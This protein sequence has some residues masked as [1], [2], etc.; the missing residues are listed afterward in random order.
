M[1]KLSEMLRV[2]TIVILAA[3]VIASCQPAPAPTEAPPP[4]PA[5]T[6]APAEP[7]LTEAPAKTE[8]PVAEGKVDTT[9]YKKDGPYVVCFSNASVSNSWRVSMVEHVRYAVDVFKDKGLIKEYFETDANDDPNKQISDTEDLLSKGCDVLIVSASQSEPLTPVVE[10]AFDQ[11]IPVV[12]LDR[13]IASEKYVTFVEQNSCDMGA[14]QAEWLV[15]KIGKKGNVVLLSG[16]AGATP[17][18]DRLRCAQET[19]AKYPDIKVLAQ[20]YASWS[21]VEGKKIMENWLVTFPQI[22]AVWAD[23]GLQ[24]SGAVEAFVEAG[25]DVPPITGE[26]FNRYLKQWKEMGFEGYAVSFNVRMGYKAVEI[27]LA[28]LKGLPVPHYVS[29]D[30]IIIDSS[31]LDQYVRMDLPDDYWAASMPE[32]AARLFP[33][34]SFEQPTA[35]P[36]VEMVD[37]TKYKKDGPYVVCFSNASVSNSWRVS[38]VEHVRYA[39]DVFKDKGLIKEYFETDANDDPNK[40]ISDTEDLL[41]KGCDVLI[42]SAS[43]SEPLTPVVEKAFDQGIPVVTLDRNIASEKYVTF[44]EQNSC[45]MGATQAEWLVE[46][47]G[48]KGNVVLL[49][50]LAGATPAEDRLRCAQET[51]AKYPDIKVLAQAYA[52]WSPVEG[53]KIMEN[54][55]VTFPQIDAVWADSGLQGSGA[56]EA[57]VEA[58]MDVPPITGEDFNRYL[59]QWKEMGFEGYAVSF[60]VRMGYKAVEIA[61]AILKGLPVPHYVSVDKI[62]IDSSNL[63]Q[64]VRMDL[65]DDYWAASMPEVAARLFP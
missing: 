1:N 6:E 61:L 14:T 42:V 55:L 26:D 36:G 7:A 24:G 38:M 65:P 34:G 27:A 50:G 58:G 53:K 63:D 22:D 3:L 56:V 2:L 13:N 25:M 51:F 16:L 57:F 8:A 47:I 64:Y 10:K 5:Q 21:P 62:I 40:Q 59:K 49:S 54:W 31:N 45:D 30:K 60:N 48:K 43:Q 20:A 12:T 15:E 4:Q 41:S 29:V 19:F 46:K 33:E 35:E 37:T 44:V 52:S 32:V 9:K 23:S 28:I 17:A 11:G 18:E 39:V